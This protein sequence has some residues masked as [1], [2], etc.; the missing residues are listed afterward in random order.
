METFKK[1]VGRPPGKDYP[2]R[3]L[4]CLKDDDYRRLRAKAEQEERS[5]SQLARRAVRE[6]LDREEKR[7]L[8]PAD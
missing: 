6:F 2:S 7:V 4:V 8:L 1:R 5:M 3:I